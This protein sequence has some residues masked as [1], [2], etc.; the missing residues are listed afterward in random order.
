MFFLSGDKFRF[1]REHKK[2]EV[3]NLMHRIA[4]ATIKALQIDIE[5][6]IAPRVDGGIDKNF[7]FVHNFKFVVL[8]KFKRAFFA[9][10]KAR[11]G[12]F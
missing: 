10:N 9:L 4:R 8:V 11:I 1:V 5:R 2:G 3:A 7:I 6:D 12:G